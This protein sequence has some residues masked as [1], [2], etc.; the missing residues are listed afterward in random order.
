MYSLAKQPFIT[1]PLSKQTVSTKQ[2]HTDMYLP[3]W[4]LHLCQISVF[5]IILL[6]FC[7]KQRVCI[8]TYLST[9]IITLT[10]AVTPMMKTPNS[11]VIISYSKLCS[12]T[13]FASHCSFK[14]H[15]QALAF[16]AFADQTLKRSNFGVLRD[17]PYY[18]WT[19]ILRIIREQ[20]SGLSSAE[21]LLG[22][23]ECCSV[24]GLS[25][26]T[27][28]IAGMLHLDVRALS[29][30]KPTIFAVHIQ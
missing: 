2:L 8:Y 14:L 26:G 21:W 23:H 18:G 19:A 7:R 11:A 30:L 16:T 22:N 6:L 4:P 15:T 28:S 3:D 29:L 13:G 27:H 12:F 1:I 20:L 10:K 25:L 17:G 5:S 24:F 9:D